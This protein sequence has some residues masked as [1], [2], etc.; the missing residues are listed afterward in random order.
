MEATPNVRNVF[1][2]AK[3]MC[4]L[5]V[6]RRVWK[7]STKYW[8]QIIYLM[9][10]TDII[11]KNY[12]VLNLHYGRKKMSNQAI[13]LFR[14]SRSWHY[15]TLKKHQQFLTKIEISLISSKALQME[16]YGDFR[17]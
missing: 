15:C 3:D 8:N 14:N 16:V 9:K 11:R 5:Q 10:P 17:F 2:P 6:I 12:I 13:W 7:V 1:V 4:M